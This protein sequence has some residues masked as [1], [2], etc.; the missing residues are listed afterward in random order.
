M[1]Q[2]LQHFPYTVI[3]NGENASI[4][5]TVYKPVWNCQSSED[6]KTDRV[7]GQKNTKTD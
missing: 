1:N 4:D 2:K 3:V 6:I 5:L 7:H